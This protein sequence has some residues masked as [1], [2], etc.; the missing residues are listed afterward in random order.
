MSNKSFSEKIEDG[1]N[2][3]NGLTGY[4]SH[5]HAEGIV[6]AINNEI[7]RSMVNQEPLSDDLLKSINMVS[8]AYDIPVENFV[9]DY[10]E[11]MGEDF[12]TSEL[13]SNIEKSI[14][15]YHGGNTENAKKAMKGVRDI[16][17]N[18]TQSQQDN[19]SK[20]T[21]RNRILSRNLFKA[22][23]LAFKKAKKAKNEKELDMLRNQVIDVL[24]RVDY[25]ELSN[26]EMSKLL[27]YEKPL[28]DIFNISLNREK[29]NYE[30]KKSNKHKLITNEIQNNISALRP[31]DLIEQLSGAKQG[32]PPYIA[33]QENL[34]ALNDI[35]SQDKVN[36]NLTLLKKLGYIGAI[37]SFIVGI[38][39][40][41]FDIEY[42]FPH[43]TEVLSPVFIWGFGLFGALLVMVMI[44]IPLEAM[45]N[46]RYLS[47]TRKILALS[48]LVGIPLKGYIDYK[49]VRNYANIVAEDIRIKN[50]NNSN[51]SMGAT[52]A[53]SKEMTEINKKSLEDI[54]KQLDIYN[55][56]LETYEEKRKPYEKEEERFK[57]LMAKGYTKWRSN[58]LKRAEENL[59]IFDRE[60]AS[61]ENHIKQLEAKR[62]K[63]M[64]II[65]QNTSKA[66]ETIKQS[67]EL[68]KKEATSRFFMMIALLGLIELSSLLHVLSDYLRV[69]NTPVTVAELAKIQ[70][71]VDANTAIRTMTNRVKATLNEIN[72]EQGN[73]ALHMIN[74]QAYSGIAL[75]NNLIANAQKLAKASNE[76]L[77][78]NMELVIEMMSLHG[79]AVNSK[80]LANKVENIMRLKELGM[81][82]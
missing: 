17:T 12:D 64:G 69:K 14:K 70:N 58:G 3:Q 20:K 53:I 7:Y 76:N 65:S 33:M 59:R 72:I 16:N 67:E 8:D 56:R 25:R 10:L 54:N 78:K 36:K 73:Q 28:Y 39:G 77:S 18:T 32:E 26:D 2:K 71:I 21:Q 22:L 57:K 82:K 1:L 60:K 47:A 15:D 41:H 13:K 44:H 30:E 79:E 50:L 38:F 43:M 52:I 29:K 11:A 75:E 55:K 34:N 81:L 23:D 27:K 6:N 40:V 19:N 66:V 80:K 42:H 46:D 74:H 63:I 35:H 68:A 45:V 4:D 61:I 62:D 24:D 49:A 37:M 31:F 9:N 48:L 51:K 5:T